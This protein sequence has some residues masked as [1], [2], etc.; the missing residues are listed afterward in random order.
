VQDVSLTAQALQQPPVLSS[1]AG[2]RKEAARAQT[3]RHL[4][5][6]EKKSALKYFEKESAAFQQAPQSQADDRWPDLFEHELGKALELPLQWRRLEFS[7]AA[8]EHPRVRYS[9]VTFQKPKK[10]ISQRRL[11]RSAGISR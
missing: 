8:I 4:T 7:K 5:T 1:D 11:T 2:S 3:A 6:D 9:S 10:S